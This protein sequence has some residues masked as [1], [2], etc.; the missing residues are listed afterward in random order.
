MKIFGAPQRRN[1]RFRRRLIGIL[2]VGAGLGIAW[3]LDGPPVLEPGDPTSVV[4]QSETT[5]TFRV[6]L[7]A[8]QATTLSVVQHGVDVVVEVQGDDGGTF[9]VDSPTGRHGVEQVYLATPHGAQRWVVKLR[10]FSE[11]TDPAAGVLLRVESPGVQTAE[12]LRRYRAEILFHRA[13]QAQE[14][15]S[16]MLDAA[17]D[18][19]FTEAAELFDE[20]GDVERQADALF[21]QGSLRAQASRYESASASYAASVALAERPDSHVELARALSILGR[22]DAAQVSLRRALHLY[23]ERESSAHATAWQNLGSLQRR[24]GYFEAAAM[25]LQ[26]AYAMFQRT[27]PRTKRLA[28]LNSLGE[29]RLQQ[30]A[31]DQALA[32]LQQALQEA[33]PEDRKVRA[34]TLM[35][36]ADVQ[37]K[38]GRPEQ[39]AAHY[40]EAL[41]GVAG[42]GSRLEASLRVGQGRLAHH[43]GDL[44][45]ARRAYRQALEI[46]ETLQVPLDEAICRNNLAWLD[47]EAGDPSAARLGFRRTLDEIRL[48]RGAALEGVLRFGLAK[49]SQQLGDWREAERQ[50]ALAVESV[51]LL[52]ARSAF[53]DRMSVLA[54]RHHVFDAYVDLL[55]QQHEMLP[56]DELQRLAWAVAEQAKARSF[57]DVIGEQVATEIAGAGSGQSALQRVTLEPPTVGQRSRNSAARRGE[58]ARLG[59]LRLDLDGE[60]RWLRQRHAGL[61]PGA[62]QAHVAHRPRWVLQ[63]VQDEL[64]DDSSLLL[65]YHLG[66]LGSHLWVVG[67]TSVQ[68]F[69]LGRTADIEL[70]VRQLN[71][72]MEN[73]RLPG[74]EQRL[75][76]TLHAL[77]RAILPPSAALQGARRL[78]IVPSGEL[79]RAPFA[80]L[81]WPRPS[82]RAEGVEG[83]PPTVL[84]ERF[85]LAF[86]PSTS[87]LMA[88][89]AQAAER[90]PAASGIAI[91]ADPVFARHDPRLTAVR[92]VTGS[93]GASFD[94]LDLS[95]LEHSELEAAAIVEAVGDERAQVYLGLN[96]QTSTILDGALDEVR[97]VHFATHGLTDESS[98]ENS[99]LML[100]QWNEKGRR[101]DGRLTAR[102]V[103]SLRLKADLVVLSACRSGAGRPL[104][105]EGLTGLARSFL[106][107]GARRVV[108]SL[109]SVDDRAAAALMRSFYGALARGLP[110]A[111]ALRL[112]QQEL[113]LGEPWGA[114]YYWAGFALFGD[115]Q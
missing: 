89:R 80:A 50:I 66:K 56:M 93:E 13:R 87:V 7:D 63:Q 100:S 110:A 58:A 79:F 30:G 94:G 64:L 112:A 84:M 4:W 114:P 65:S 76:D 106:V 102:Q 111:E 55:M 2:G 70:R 95:R 67:R 23:G 77:S 24:R 39:A 71:Q 54:S 86:L 25:S 34:Q 35:L 20:L 98:P 53:D 91:F 6:D 85:E 15:R 97:F 74:A 46:F 29:L 68:S 51:E 88:S 101:Q 36:L 107:A 73:R 83:A 60:L 37:M 48:L 11:P 40:R 75:Q 19:Q 16:H 22:W 81:P 108:V 41:E 32:S 1:R 26:R 105:G 92:G 72:L 62:T 82:A 33:R 31:L 3:W 49:S 113:R 42:R 103:A 38:S 43:L 78:I 61:A 27:G 44:E 99:F 109:W 12:G 14:R 9:E 96:A 28:T 90:M 47:L 5:P 21:L 69:E 59:T 57:L 45:G 104:R 17:A 115:W 52:R 8:G 18:G 10:A